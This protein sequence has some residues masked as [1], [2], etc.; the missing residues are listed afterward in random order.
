MRKF[1]LFMIG[2]LAVTSGF[3]QQISGK[4]QA[5]DGKV[6]AG[7]T[8]SLLKAKDSSVAKLSISNNDGRFSF[9]GIKA[10]RYL[11]SASHVGYKLGYSSAF[12]YSSSETTNL[13]ALQLSKT[14]SELRGVTVSS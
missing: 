2:C 9:D 11:V 7:S 6:L 1:G 3:A 13:P 5:R 4:I 10:G 8:I 12:E 14:A